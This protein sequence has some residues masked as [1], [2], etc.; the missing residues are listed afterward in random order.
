[1][2]VWIVPVC[3]SLNQIVKD[4]ALAKMGSLPPAKFSVDQTAD[5]GDS[6]AAISQE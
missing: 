5:E 4:E 2:G 1:M 6:N 3:L